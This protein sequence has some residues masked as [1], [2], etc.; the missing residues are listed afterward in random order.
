M[1][2][3]TLAIAA[4]VCFVCLVCFALCPTFHLARWL[5]VAAIAG[6][7]VL[8]FLHPLLCTALLVL[9]GVAVF[10]TRYYKR[11][12]VHALPKLPDRSA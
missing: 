8:L 2:A 1:F 12:I 3:V 6:V 10:F 5:G 9:G 4:L 7:A 11:R